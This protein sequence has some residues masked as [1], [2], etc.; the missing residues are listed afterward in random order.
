[1]VATTDTWYNGKYI[2]DLNTIMKGDRSI[3]V[4][5][6]CG[7]PQAN[8]PVIISLSGLINNVN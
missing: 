4:S 3:R 8:N 2:R 5:D 7:A 1:M 6:Y